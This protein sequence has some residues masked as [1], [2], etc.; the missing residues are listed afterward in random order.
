M[1]DQ[2][3]G[4]PLTHHQVH[5][6]EATGVTGGLSMHVVTAGPEDGTPVVLLHGFPD[7]WY[8]WRHHIPLLARRGYR[9]IVPDQR[10]YAGTDKPQATRAYRVEHLADD[11]AGLLTHFRTGPAHLVGHDWGGGVAWTVAM[12]H[13]HRLRTLTVFNCPRPEVLR[14]APLR[15]PRQLLRSWYMLFFQFPWVPQKFLASGKAVE[16]LRGWSR[17]GT[18]TEADLVHYR[19]AFT[20]ECMRGAVSWYR[21]AMTHAGPDDPIHTPTLLVWGQRD[22]ALAEH[23]APESLQ[24]CTDGRLELLPDVGHWTPHDAPERTGALL[25]AHLRAH[26][27]PDPYVYKIVQRATWDAAP[28]PWPGA[29]VDLHDGFV[30]LSSRHQVHGTL[31][32]HFAGQDDLELL[33]ID[34]SRLPEGALRWEV[35]RNSERF[36]HVYAPLPKDAAVQRIDVPRHARGHHLLEKRF[37]RSA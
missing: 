27:G 25:L 1:I 37:E 5:L 13:P 20:E 24:T 9:V 17:P 23:L 12:R 29:P 28:D 18:F 21:A 6:P 32:K 36:P 8:G 33:A 19:Q 14:T 3:D 11:V 34:P 15:D 10:G 22:P 30:H 16:A 7:F 2:L 35:S 26:G 4:I 31:T